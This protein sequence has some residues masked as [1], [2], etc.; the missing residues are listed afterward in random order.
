MGADKHTEVRRQLVRLLRGVATRIEPRE[1]Q[2]L[3]AGSP[4]VTFSTTGIQ[5]HDPDDEVFW[6]GVRRDMPS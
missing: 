4:A 3:G 2:F 6:R 1:P 5:Y